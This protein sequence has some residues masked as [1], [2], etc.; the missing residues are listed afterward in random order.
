MAIKSPCRRET[1]RLLGFDPPETFRTQ[2]TDEL[3]RE[4]KV[5]ERPSS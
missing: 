2:C 4:L 1:Y 5:P 3:A